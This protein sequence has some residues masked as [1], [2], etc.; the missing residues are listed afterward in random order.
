[1]TDYSFYVSDIGAAM[2]LTFANKISAPSFRL[3]TAANADLTA[4]GIVLSTTGADNCTGNATFCSMVIDGASGLSLP[5][6]DNANLA[7]GQD[8]LSAYSLQSGTFATVPLPIA[9][10]MLL[11]AIG[12]LAP[13]IRRASV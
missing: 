3:Q 4:W 10:V 12:S 6:F 5:P 11:G 13:F 1:V 7:I 2:S 8:F 9:L